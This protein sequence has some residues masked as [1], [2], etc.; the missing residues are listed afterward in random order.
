MGGGTDRQIDYH[1][2]QG[3][4]GVTCE[5]QVE[6][7]DDDGTGQLIPYRIVITKGI[8]SDLVCSV[9]NRV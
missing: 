1:D 7:P 9:S 8:L 5:F 3:P 6:H 4:F 2:I